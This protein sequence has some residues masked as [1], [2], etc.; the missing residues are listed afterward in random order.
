MVRVAWDA[1]GCWWKQGDRAVVGGSMFLLS[2]VRML[3]SADW[4]DVWD[5]VNVG[6]RALA[7]GGTLS[8]ASILVVGVGGALVGGTPVVWLVSTT[9]LAPW[10]VVAGAKVTCWAKLEEE[11]P[12]SEVSNWK[13]IIGFK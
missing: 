11:G 7:S 3:A 8:G 4:A 9:M 6:L 5:P 10:T 2:E 13:I 1:C 12:L